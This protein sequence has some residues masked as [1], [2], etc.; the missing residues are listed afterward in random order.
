MQRPVCKVIQRVM[1]GHQHIQIDDG[2]KCPGVWLDRFL[3]RLSTD[4]RGSQNGWSQ[5]SGGIPATPPLHEELPVSRHDRRASEIARPNPVG[6]LK[7]IGVRALLCAGTVVAASGCTTL[8]EGRFDV[9]EG[10]RK[11]E[12]QRIEPYEKLTPYQ[13]P[14]CETAPSFQATKGSTWALVRYRGGRRSRQVAVPVVPSDG[15]QTGDLV[16]VNVSECGRQIQRRA[17]AG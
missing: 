17:A 4:V 1:I 2:P 7:R 16:Y 11:G 15:Y 3:E 9:Y 8:Y 5:R 10:W 12:V 13:I 14:R 6:R